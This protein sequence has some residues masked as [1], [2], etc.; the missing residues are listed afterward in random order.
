MSRTTFQ[1]MLAVLLAVLML[2]PMTGVASAAEP[3]SA[4]SST[5]I[6]IAEINEILNAIT[7]TEYKQQYAGAN[8][9]DRV[10]TIP[11]TGYDQAS[12]TAKVAT[13][14][15]YLDRPGESLSVAES[16]LVTWK[17]NVPTAGLYAIRVNYAQVT[18]ENANSNSIERVLYINGSVPFAEA[19]SV[20]MKKNWVVVVNEDGTYDKDVNGN[21]IRPAQIEAP[22]WMSW[23]LR[24]SDGYY[25]NPYEFY[26]EAGENAITL[27][28]IR[29]AVVIE[30][31]ELVPYEDLLTYEEYLAK[32]AGASNVTGVAPIIIEGEDIVSASDVT[33]YPVNDRVSAITSPQSADTSLLNAVGGEEWATAGQWITYE[34]DVEKSGF[35]TIALRFKQSWQSGLDVA[36]RVYIDGKVPF[37][38]ANGFV[39][40]FNNSWQS[41][42]LT[43]GEEI[44]KFYL[45]EG[46]HEIKFEVTL[47]EFGSVIQ[48]ISDTLTSINADY[49][50]ILKLTGTSPDKYQDYKFESVIP[51]TLKDMLRCAGELEK[52]VSYIGEK[53]EN[54]ATLEQ[55]YM[56]LGDMVNDTDLIATKLK[57]LKSY[58]GTLGTW[59]STAKN[60][61]LMID[62]ISIQPVEDD[63]PRADANFFQSLW[64]QLRLFVASFYV[65][66]NSFGSTVEATEENTLE[67]W[68]VLNREKA[69]IIRNL[70]ENNFTPKHNIAVNIKLVAGGTLLPSVLAGVGPDVSLFEADPLEYA[71]RDAV[72]PLNQFEGFK[73]VCERYVPEALTPVTLYGNTYGLPDSMT[74]T[75]LFYRKDILADLGLEIPKTWDDL[76]AMI[77]T[78]MA[79]NMTLGMYNDSLIFQYQNGGE[80]WAD[81]GMRIN[82]DST[83]ALEAF[84][85]LCGFYKNYS[86]DYQYDFANRFRTG[87]MPI[88][89]A[90]YTTY[91]QLSVF[92]SELSGLWGF[93][94]IPGTVLEDG[95]INHDAM[96]TVTS[97]MMLKDTDKAE[98]AWKFMA[99][100]TDSDFQISYSNEVVATMGT[101]EKHNTANVEALGELPWSAEEYAALNEQMHN[102]SAVTRYPGTYILNRYVDFAFLAVYNNNA[103]AATSLLSHVNTINKEVNRKRT[104]FG[105]EILD[106]GTTLADKRMGQVLTLLDEGVLKAFDGEKFTMAESVR[107]EK[108]E[109]I[110]RVR[111]AVEAASVTKIS[112]ETVE[113]LR[114]LAAEAE[115]YSKDRTLSSADRNGWEM[116]AEFLTIAADAIISYRK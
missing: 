70:A 53:S 105:L 21:D 49:L 45:E 87:E 99:W 83:T 88:G 62:Y 89:I 78:L 104:E 101:A 27:E 115:T 37:E 47:G 103:D 28:S 69:Q 36:R 52:A 40:G 12:T 74:F 22:I 85:K 77:P 75:M 97:C 20:I 110:E 114:A 59:L 72:M 61:P 25:P 6:S 116:V 14:E 38:E 66:Y 8:R 94:S 71:I 48:S 17:F 68:V 56:I 51:D 102:L 112:D 34:F 65:D 58:L 16:G 23:E 55:I 81:D 5:S 107:E 109:Y 44:Y 15:N 80:L 54:T 35:Y 108:A 4:S 3:D 96:L 84:E 111:A 91:N 95:S 60:Q 32:H 39:F 100:Y 57:N 73:E 42:A 92:A 13:L 31:I 2:V 10:I 43:D 79:N 67:V 26:F 113:E 93:T 33:L 24:D 86:L 29:E 11:A 106:I 64:Y 46:H 1:R 82:Y 63:I 7:Y 90:Q 30:S 41:T 76:L 98:N 50:E 9:G 19:R 18:R